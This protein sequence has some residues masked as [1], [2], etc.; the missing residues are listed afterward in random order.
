MKLLKKIITPKEGGLFDK[1]CKPIIT[2]E[3]IIYLDA[4]LIVA[5]SFQ[6]LSIYMWQYEL[7]KCGFL[8]TISELKETMAYFQSM[9]FIK[10][11]YFSDN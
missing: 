11:N 6:Q 5:S 10:E 8:V 1:N 4:A 7:L 3:N 2:E 9:G